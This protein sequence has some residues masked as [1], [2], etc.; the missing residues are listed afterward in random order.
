MSSKQSGRSI[1]SKAAFFGEKDGSAWSACE[2]ALAKTGNDAEEVATGKAGKRFDEVHFLRVAKRAGYFSG[3]WSAKEELGAAH[4]W[5][6]VWRCFEIVSEDPDFQTVPC[7]KR[8]TRGALK[9]EFN[10]FFAF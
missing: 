4:E 7:A 6:E 5:V 1:H 3:G 9:G 2:I 10:V 8:F